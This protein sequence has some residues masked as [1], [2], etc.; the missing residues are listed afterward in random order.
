MG[1]ARKGIISNELKERQK[2]LRHFLHE[3]NITH[4]ELRPIGFSIDTRTIPDDKVQEF[5]II[6]NKVKYDE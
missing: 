3:N 4:K 2:Q 1:K 5:L 6:A